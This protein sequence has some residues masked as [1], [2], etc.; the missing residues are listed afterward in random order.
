[1]I[2]NI[3]H[4][5][6][7]I[8]MTEP[9]GFCFNPETAASNVFQKN[10]GI[11]AQESELRARRE[12]ETF[13]NQLTDKGVYVIVAKG[14]PETP[15][16]V[17]PNNIFST[18][19][20]GEFFYFPMANSNRRLERQIK[21][22]DILINH[23]FEIYDLIDLSH[24]ESQHQF[25]EGTGSMVM[26]HPYQQ[27]FMTLSNRSN[28]EALTVFHSH[29]GYLTM[30]LEAFDELK[31]AIYHTNVVISTGRQWI[32]ACLEAINNP[33][34]IRYWSSSCNIELIEISRHQMN[35]F[36]ANVLEVNGNNGPIGVISQTA[37][38][39]YSPQQKRAWEKYLEPL[40]VSIPT[41]ETIGGGSARCMMAEIFLPHI[42]S[43]IN[44]SF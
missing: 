37:W 31:T 22:H 10:L 42:S 15:D 19:I 28:F 25:L 3:P 35:H 2:R 30:V 38:D 7:N 26:H 1:M 43:K 18:T 8:L 13:V 14:S 29:K 27:L 32:I 41:I 23:G 16:A 21:Y 44:S 34:R 40:I 24:L 36:G 4:S 9:I 33:D 12:F 11:S 5:T 17:F 20:D 39:T 6:G